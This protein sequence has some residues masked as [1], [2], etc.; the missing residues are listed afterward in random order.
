MQLLS[1]KG[2]CSLCSPSSIPTPGPTRTVSYSNTPQRTP[3][4][5]QHRS[6][7]GLTSACNQG[8][9]VA[10]LWTSESATTP[11]VQHQHYNV[12]IVL[13]HPEIQPTDGKIRYWKTVGVFNVLPEASYARTS[14]ILRSSSPAPLPLSQARSHCSTQ[15]SKFSHC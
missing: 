6:G 8:H 4:S 1:K 2:G 14:G 12:S 9:Q 10:Q 11:Q 13:V 15:G 5:L 3:R 7:D